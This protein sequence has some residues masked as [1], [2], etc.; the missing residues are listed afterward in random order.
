MRNARNGVSFMSG[1]LCSLLFLTAAH[2]STVSFAGSGPEFNSS[3]KG[4]TGGTEASLFTVK[5]GTSGFSA[6]EATKIAE[7]LTDWTNNNQLQGNCSYVAFEAGTP[8]K[9]TIKTN[10]GIFPGKPGDAAVTGSYV[11]NN[12]TAKILQ[13]ATTTFYWGSNLWNRN[14]PSA[15]HQQFVLKVMLHEAG[16]T[17]GLQH[18]TAQV[19]QGSILNVCEEVNDAGNEVPE[20]VQTIDNNKIRSIGQY[21]ANCPCQQPLVYDP[22]SIVCPAGLVWNGAECCPP[23]CPIV[24]DVEG[25]GFDLTDATGGVLFDM[26]GNGSQ[27]RVAWMATG[28]DDA[29]LTLD[30]NGN[31]VVDNGTELFGNVSAQ[32]ASLEPNGFLALAEFDKP[33][34]GGNADG[35]IDGLDAIS[36]SLRFWQDTNHNGVSEA[37]E[38]STTS[39]RG[40][41]RFGLEYQ[42]SRRID[43]HGNEFRFRAKVYDAW[44]VRAGRWAWDVFLVSAPQ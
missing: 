30:T 37:N 40:I 38:L 11:V 2:R 15:P 16:H 4:W 34:N 44:G 3:Q 22:P 1:M 7:A 21:L 23:T 18:P 33:E 19:D 12:S 43:E 36:S 6:A 42:E 39:E 20:A 14:G 32:P 28:S 13:S 5:Y 8:V 25:D 29:W 17:M 24:V 41:G 31:G 27:V 26:K 35:Y 9:Y 10:A